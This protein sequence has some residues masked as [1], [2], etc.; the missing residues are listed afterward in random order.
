MESDAFLN[1]DPINI[2]G[3]GIILITAGHQA[4]LGEREKRDAGKTRQAQEL[5]QSDSE[6][7]LKLFSLR[8]NY[9][10]GHYSKSD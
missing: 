10:I 3:K 6:P 5:L 4:F 1:I 7:I 8:K 2:R 9:K